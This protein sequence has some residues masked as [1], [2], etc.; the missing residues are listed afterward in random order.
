MKALFPLL[1][2]AALISG[3]GSVRDENSKLYAVRP[4]STPVVEETLLSDG[5]VSV[6]S[7]QAWVDLMPGVGWTGTPKTRLQVRFLANSQGCTNG[8]QFEAKIIQAGD[9]QTL[10]IKRKVKD[11]CGEPMFRTELNHT[12]EGVFQAGKPVFMNGQEVAVFESIIN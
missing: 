2:N 6:V 4:S 10:V 11:T 9:I 8:D 5:G 7:L 12:V 3:C 1:L